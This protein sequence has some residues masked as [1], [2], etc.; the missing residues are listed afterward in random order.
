MG[1]VV[2]L[3]RNTLPALFVDTTGNGV[4]GSAAGSGATGTGA[5]IGG[6]A[7]GATL[8]PNQTTPRE[9]RNVQ[10]LHKVVSLSVCSDDTT[11]KKHNQNKRITAIHKHFSKQSQLLSI[12]IHLL[13]PLLL[14]N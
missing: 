2:V 6:A 11:P 12:I 9:S 3:R 7:G 5:S 8:E 10:D 1:G 14:I 4:V 13:T